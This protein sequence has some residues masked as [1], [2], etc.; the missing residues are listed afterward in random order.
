VRELGKYTSLI[1]EE[2]YCDPV[3]SLS[4]VPRTTISA[5]VD[6]KK[7]WLARSLRYVYPDAENSATDA[8]L[9]L[10]QIILHHGAYPF[11]P[12]SMIPP[13]IKQAAIA[14]ALLTAHDKAITIREVLEPHTTRWR[15]RNWNQRSRLLFQ[16]LCDTDWSQAASKHIRDREDDED[17]VAALDSIS[18]DNR[19]IRGAVF[20]IARTLP[21]SYSRTLGG[22]VSLRDMR[23]LLA[24]VVVTGMG[25]KPGEPNR[26]KAA[27]E[28]TVL[29]LLG[30]FADPDGRINWEEFQRLTA[31]KM[32]CSLLLQHNFANI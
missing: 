22:T 15:P 24:L 18:P 13:T 25:N 26:E 6:I 23:A 2:A 4:S 32:V 29:A 9:V 5:C 7:E 3:S 21:S 19:K 10:L 14:V 16:S 17:L 27:V 12:P 28:S 31:S 30:D 11:K 1:G 20:K 8:V